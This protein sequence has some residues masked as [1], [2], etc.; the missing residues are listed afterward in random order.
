MTFSCYSCMGSLQIS[1]ADLFTLNFSK[2]NEFCFLE[3]LAII[4]KHKTCVYEVVVQKKIQ[5]RQHLS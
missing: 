5:S 1:A 2:L 4:G 3:P